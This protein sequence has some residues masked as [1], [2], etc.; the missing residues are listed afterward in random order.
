MVAGQPR[1]LPFDGPLSFAELVR[2][3]SG[4]LPARAVLDELLRVGIVAETSGLIRLLNRTGYVPYQDEQAKVAIAGDAAADLLATLNHNLA[5][6]TR[7]NGRLQL[8]VA[9]DNLPRRVLSGFQTMS[10]DE[11]L[12]WL[13]RFDAWLREFDRDVTGEESEPADTFR[14]GIGIDYFEE[15]IPHE[16]RDDD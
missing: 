9:Y 3:Y 8:S 15:K 2:R 16:D 5:T 11:S 1:D 4:D 10:H 6:T 14:A 7:D 13:R 12:V